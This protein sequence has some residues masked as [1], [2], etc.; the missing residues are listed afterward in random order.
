MT[1]LVALRAIPGTISIAPGQEFIEPIQEQADHWLSTGFAKR[2]VVANGRGWSGL[3]WGSQ[4]VAILA[5]G[6]SLSLEQAEAVKV[7]RNR[8]PM[9]RK[10]IAINTTF[11]RAPWADV[12]YACD[13]TWWEGRDKPGQETYLEQARAT[14]AGQFWTQDSAAAAKHSLNLIRSISGGGLCTKPGVVY[15]CGNSGGQ[16]VGLAHQA[17]AANVYLLGFDMKGGHWHGDHPAGLKRVQSFPVFLKQMERM[18]VEVAAIKD[19]RVI[20]CTPGSALKGFPVR[21]W[22]EVFA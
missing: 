2:P 13:G 17:G 14:F 19:F 9:M 18:A 22:Q 21:K 5:S 3:N 7:W 20:N 4:D 11:R 8:Q 1:R 15:Q 6:E 12:L 16:A 10:V